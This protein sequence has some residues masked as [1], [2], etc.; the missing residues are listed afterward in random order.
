M[1]KDNVPSGLG[2]DPAQFIAKYSNTDTA[3]RMLR[4]TNKMS[5]DK[6]SNGF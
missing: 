1:K 5:W 4:G 2:G 3:Q 6:N